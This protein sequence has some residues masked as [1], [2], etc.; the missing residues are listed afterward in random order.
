MLPSKGK[1]EGQE[2]LYCKPQNGLGLRYKNYLFFEE[3]GL[4]DS[5]DGLKRKELE[6]RINSSFLCL[7]DL[8]ETIG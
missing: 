3:N 4:E 5:D 8:T 1:H 7:I 6:H 2:G